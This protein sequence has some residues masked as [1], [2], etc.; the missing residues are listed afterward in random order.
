MNLASYTQALEQAERISVEIEQAM[1][2]IY[3]DYNTQFTSAL[4]TSYTESCVGF[5]GCTLA[6]SVDHEGIITESRWVKEQLGL[7]EVAA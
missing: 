4:L 3:W 6:A 7:A 2:V 1:V 5:P